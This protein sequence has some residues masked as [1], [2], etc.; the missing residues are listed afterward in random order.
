M[1]NPGECERLLHDPERLA[2]PVIGIA[3]TWTMPCNLTQREL[4]RHVAAEGAVTRT[5]AEL[6]TAGYDARGAHRW[7]G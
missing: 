3:S 2:G 5:Q 4:A 7:P 6:G 1:G